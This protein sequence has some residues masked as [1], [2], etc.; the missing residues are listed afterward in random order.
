MSTYE[1]TPPAVT[2]E[3]DATNRSVRLMDMD[4]VLKANVK[5]PTSVG[6][7]TIQVDVATSSL[8]S[9]Q[10]TDLDTILGVLRDDALSQESY[11]AQ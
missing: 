6:G 2:T 4:G 10:K 3:V 1:K 7:E 9:Q 11:A 8:T 5:L